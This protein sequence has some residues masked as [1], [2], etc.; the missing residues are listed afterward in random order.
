MPLSLAR[1]ALAAINLEA[2]FPF[3]LPH[4]AARVALKARAGSRFAPAPFVPAPPF[5]RPTPMS[6]GVRK[7]LRKLRFEGKIWI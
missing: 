3:I 7:T 1:Q 2:K 5:H 4:A 6:G